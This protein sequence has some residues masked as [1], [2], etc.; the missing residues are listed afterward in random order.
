[1]DDADE[2]IGATAYDE[3]HRQ[4]HRMSIGID[5]LDGL[6]IMASHAIDEEIGVTG[7]QV[8]ALIKCVEFSLLTTQRKIVVALEGQGED[9][10]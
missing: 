7:E 1:M 8:S 2:S 5:A 9:F 3:I 6:S 10:H 4:M